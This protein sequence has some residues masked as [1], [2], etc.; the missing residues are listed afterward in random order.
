VADRENHYERAFEEYLRQ[1]R[2]AYVAV[3]ETRRSLLGESTLKSLDFL[4][5]TTQGGGW[6]V[7]VK[8]RQFPSGA[9]KQYW[10]N[11]STSDDLAS[12]AGW[13]RVFDWRFAGLF[14]FAYRIVGDLAPLPA[15]ELFSCKGD[16]Y[17]FVG[18][19]LADYRQFARPISRRWGTVAMPT[20][21]FRRLAVPLGELL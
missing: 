14:V 10:K 15:D 21:E 16:L 4:V 3:D 1:R 11:W 5:S 13:E 9:Q 6:L 19:R 12:L 18:I 8:G 7:D 2:V 20:A 17:G